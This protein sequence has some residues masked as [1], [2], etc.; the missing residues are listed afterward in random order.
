MN[1]ERG[2]LRPIELTP[3]SEQ[4]WVLLEDVTRADVNRV[5]EIYEEATERYAAP[6]EEEDF[7]R[8]RDEFIDEMVL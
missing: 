1:R 3:A 4:Y 2:S 6:I 8:L 7:N 5:L